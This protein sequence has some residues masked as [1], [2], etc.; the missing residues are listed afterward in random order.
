MLNAFRHQ[1]FLRRPLGY[2]LKERLVCSTPF[3]IKDSCGAAEF[4]P[5]LERMCS[6]PF[7]I[8]DS[9]G[10]GDGGHLGMTGQVCST[11]FGIK[12]SCGG[13]EIVGDD[14]IRRCSTPFGIKD[15]CGPQG[16]QD[17]GVP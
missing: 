12:D 3:G 10:G 6:T 15:S 14:Q 17:A 2:V 11:P 8:K 16:P 1:R 9:C 4:F 5:S 13:S 7:G